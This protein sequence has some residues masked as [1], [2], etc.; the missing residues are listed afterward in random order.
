M[1]KWNKIKFRKC[2]IC[3]NDLVEFLHNQK[4]I[5]PN[6]YNLPN[7]YDLVS[8]KK[9][10]FVY[11]D[12]SA[13][14]N[15]YDKYYETL[16]KYESKV[17]GTGSGI[18]GYDKKR[19]VDFSKMISEFFK[20]KSISILDVGCA[21]GGLLKELQ[22]IGFT[23][24]IGMDPSNVCVNNVKKIGINAV[25]GN[26]SQGNIGNSFNNYKYDLII[27][28][29]VLEH[30]Y[31]LEKAVGFISN[32]LKENGQVIIRV[33]DATKYSTRYIVPYY[34][35]DIEH[36]NHFSLNDINN[37]FKNNGF[38][39]IAYGET[40]FFVSDK[41]KYPDIYSIFKKNNV[42]NISRIDY[43]NKSKK[44]I[45]N[46]INKS[47][48]DREILN[49]IEALYNNNEEIL[50]WGA[51]MNT[52]RLLATSLLGKCNILSFI[53]NDTKKQ[54]KLLNGIPIIPS[55]NI[56]NYKCKILL[57]SAFS[58]TKIQMQLEELGVRN[59]IIS[60]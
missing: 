3:N 57:C 58:N 53:D 47:K 1:R 10:G 13:D 18:N 50:V 24:L 2:P 16:S 48:K 14:Q 46:F 11:A 32:N 43:S 17:V 56:K 52:Y 21:N 20:D 60:L 34:Y 41:F 12:T 44:R 15:S 35:F 49:N 30:I 25:K 29:G 40:G 23:N 6:E 28:T 59:N 54:G 33:P 38:K 8:C 45:S 27:M 36:I 7:Y 9:C 37:L 55:N 4:F 22:V 5:I 26:I 31:D 51:G 42:G 19:L 39:R